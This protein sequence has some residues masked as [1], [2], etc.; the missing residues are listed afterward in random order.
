MLW[1][2][3]YFLVRFFESH[4]CVVYTERA[5]HRY[6]TS[7]QKENKEWPAANFI[8]KLIFR[9]LSHN[10]PSSSTKTIQHLK[11]ANSRLFWKQKEWLKSSKQDIA[12]LF[13]GI[14]GLTPGWAELVSLGR[15]S[16]YGMDPREM[17]ICFFSW[18]KCE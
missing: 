18:I 3:K 14:I 15:Q 11:T 5:Q 13:Q 1:V 7:G 16:A 8:L 4:Y 17:S 10:K 6:S 9:K 12:V 2:S